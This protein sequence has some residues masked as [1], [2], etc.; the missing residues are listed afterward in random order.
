M[1]VAAA[2]LQVNLAN[3]AANTGDAAGDTFISIENIRGSGLNDT[4]VGDGDNNLLRGGPGG[5]SL[6]GGAGIDLADY[7]GS[8]VGLQVNLAN[9][10]AN[11]GEAIGDTYARHRRHPWQ[12]PQRHADRRRWQQLPARRSRRRQP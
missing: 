2:G 3:S 7:G 1:P 10:G 12:R 11:T 9:P 6:D 5:D 4:L 8:A